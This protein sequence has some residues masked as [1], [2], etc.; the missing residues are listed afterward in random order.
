[1]K[2]DAANA[3]RMQSVRE[4]ARD[5]SRA[6]W[7]DSGACRAIEGLYPDDRVRSGP[8]FRILFFALTV[9]AIIGAV[10]IVSILFSDRDAVAMIVLGTG[11]LCAGMTEFLIGSKRRCQGGIEAAFSV[12]A[13]VGTLVGLLLVMDRLGMPMDRHS[14]TKFLFIFALVTG[15]A[16]WRWGYWPYAALSAYFT[17]SSIC[18][19]PAGRWLWLA[20]V[21]V[22][23]K[24]LVA[25]YDSPRLPPSLRRSSAAFLA[26]CLLA[27]YAAVNVFMLDHQ[28]SGI[29][30][31]YQ[32]TTAD[33]FPRWLS[34]VLTAA[35]PLLVLLIGII[36]RR[37]LFLYE[38]LLL[39]ILSCITLRFYF[40]IAPAWVVLTGAG[41]LMFA[42]A[43]GIR[44]FLDSGADGERGGLTA[45][46]LAED[47]GKRRRMEALASVATM[48][49]EAATHVQKSE[50]QGGGGKFGGGG[51]SG[52]F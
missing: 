8:A 21:L 7:I 12:A 3:D 44:R 40:H 30:F 39:T 37:L 16:A 24:G 52:D 5:W 23:Y 35:L 27:L 10:G 43:A 38:G 17:A 14:M 11:L 36:E 33:P 19:L 34:I 31:S 20:A 1:M 15:A 4:A 51:A 29:F 49:P 45:A 50:F 22:A 28:S 48:T 26:V 2:E 9:G 13:L 25:A 41:L 6:G 42:I 32:S 47:P 46:P 18:S